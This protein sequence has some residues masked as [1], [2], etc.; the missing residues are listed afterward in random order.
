MAVVAT[1]CDATAAVDI[2]CIKTPNY[3]AHTMTA[4][5]ISAKHNMCA[6]VCDCTMFDF[7]LNVDFIA[8]DICDDGKA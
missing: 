1:T 2:G 8:A 4:A 5:A 3:P 7:I 6:T